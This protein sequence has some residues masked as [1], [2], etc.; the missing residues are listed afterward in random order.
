MIKWKTQSMLRVVDVFPPHGTEFR[1]VAVHFVIHGA[2][3]PELFK[4]P[5]AGH[6]SWLKTHHSL[7]CPLV[8]NIIRTVGVTSKGL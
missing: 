5:N 4:Q 3:A 2:A 7:F 8:M 6:K 1:Q